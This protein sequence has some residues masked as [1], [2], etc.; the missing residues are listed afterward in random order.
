[1]RLPIGSTDVS[2]SGGTVTLIGRRAN[3]WRSIASTEKPLDEAV[4]LLE[5]QAHA[6][7]DP[8]F[9]EAVLSSDADAPR[10]VPGQSILWRYGRH[11][12]AVRVIR[13]DERGLVI[14]IPPGSSRLEP[15]PADGRRHRDVPLDERFLEPW[16]MREKTWTGQGVVRVAPTG[17][18]WSVWFF[19]RA[20]GSP[21]GV[22]VNLEL[23]HRRGTGE[24]SS[25]FSNDLVLDIWIDAEHVG[26]EDVWLKDADELEAVVRQG[27]F[28]AEQAE[29]VRV[30]ADHAG[31]DF[32]VDGAWP[33][34]EDWAHWTP[35]AEMD[36]PVA[37]PPTPLIESARRRS[38]PNSLGG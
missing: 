8:A 2:E 16:V 32:I 22:Y 4:A 18:P 30:L 37:L 5:K 29:A 13:D 7:E 38:G 11:I 10:Y 25:V 19:R 21:A 6:H 1:M 20:D 17:K 24:T 23:P 34:D 15:G 14:W 28:T 3:G 26:S 31:H 35:D 12:E 36:V 33:L 9:E 27:R